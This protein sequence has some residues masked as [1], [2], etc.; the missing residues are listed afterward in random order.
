MAA[1]I[2]GYTFSSVCYHSANSNSD[3]VSIIMHILKSYYLMFV[4]L[5]VAVH[6]CALVINVVT[7]VAAPVSSSCCWLANFGSV[8]LPAGVAKSL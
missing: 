4:S 3:H 5:L 1:S 8:Y 6:Y 2:S 7:I